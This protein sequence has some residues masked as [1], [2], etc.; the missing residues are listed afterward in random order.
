MQQWEQ[1]CTFKKVWKAVHKTLPGSLLAVCIVLL[2]YFEG[3]AVPLW[4]GGWIGGLW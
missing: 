2:L 4:V 1:I 3:I